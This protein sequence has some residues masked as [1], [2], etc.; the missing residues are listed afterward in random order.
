MPKSEKQITEGPRGGS[1][2]KGWLS[3]RHQTQ[4]SHDAAVAEHPY[5]GGYQ[6]RC[7]RA[8]ENEDERAKRSAAQQIAELDRRL[9]VGVGA[10]RERAKLA[11]A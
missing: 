8:D 3:R 9:G 1:K 5:T 4:E 6:N 10:V 7:D 2:P 11:V